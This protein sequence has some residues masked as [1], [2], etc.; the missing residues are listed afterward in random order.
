MA[1]QEVLS[2]NYNIACRQK[3]LNPIHCLKLNT[4]LWMCW[5]KTVWQYMLSIFYTIRE[6]LFQAS[7]RLPLNSN[8]SSSHIFSS[9]HIWEISFCSAHR[10]HLTSRPWWHYVLY[11][12]NPR[13]KTL[14]VT[15]PLYRVWS[16]LTFRWSLCPQLEWSS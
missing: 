8:S 2:F 9:S 3:K 10:A 15:L 6:S 1:L 11:V 14:H 5:I 4:Y 7:R 13:M 12:S 16:F